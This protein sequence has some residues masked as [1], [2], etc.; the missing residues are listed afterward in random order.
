MVDKKQP[1]PLMRQVQIVAGSLVL[2]GTLLGL[3]AA[4]GLFCYSSVCGMR[5]DFRRRQW[6]VWNGQ[7]AG[8]DAVE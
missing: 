7:T 5:F 8:R 2:G 6:L 1:L 3:F 4:P